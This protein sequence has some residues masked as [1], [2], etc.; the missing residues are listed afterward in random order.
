MR[1]A[2]DTDSVVV[3]KGASSV[4]AS[5]DGKMGINPTGNDGLARGGS[6]DVLTG[7]LLGLATQGLSVFDAA[8]SGVYLHGLAADLAASRTISRTILPTDVIRLLPDAFREAGWV[9]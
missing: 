2:R 1:L 9:T 4:I 8:V 3:L 6:G 5:P 7:L